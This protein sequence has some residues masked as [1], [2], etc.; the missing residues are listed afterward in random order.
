M[1]VKCT[2][3][4][5]AGYCRPNEFRCYG[6]DCVPKSYQC[7]GEWDC[8]DGSDEENCGGGKGFQQLVIVDD[9]D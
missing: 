1:S 9:A 7:D 6:G 3:Y 8:S 4:L 5:S 2:L